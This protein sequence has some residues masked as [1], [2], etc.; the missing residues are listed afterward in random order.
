[1]QSTHAPCWSIHRIESMQ[2]AL[3]LAQT[4]AGDESV[5]NLVRPGSTHRCGR[6]AL[7]RRAFLHR[8]L[9]LLCCSCRLE[10]LH[11]IR[12]PSHLLLQLYCVHV[13]TA[14]H[15]SLSTP[16][17]QQSMTGHPLHVP[18]TKGFSEYRSSCAAFNF[19]LLS[20]SPR[21]QELRNVK[22]LYCQLQHQTWPQR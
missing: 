20:M 18:W 12:Q 16:G 7:P 1:M 11:Q 22:E 17:R 15:H 3:C 10:R 9:R 4:E 19:V 13:C 21:T 5:Q 6:D 14:V 8:V 2:G